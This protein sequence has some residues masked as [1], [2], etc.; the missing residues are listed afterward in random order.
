MRSEVEL[1][2][3]ARLAD[4]GM[5]CAAWLRAPHR[6]GAVVPSGLPLAAAMAR[7]VPRGSG[8][9]VELGGGTGS[10]TA[11]LLHAGVPVRELII[12]ERDP[13][14]AQRLQSRFSGCRVLCGDARRLSQLLS[15]HGIG[16]PVKAVVSSLPLLIMPPGVC[17]E[18]IGGVGEL[19]ADRGP[20]VQYTYGFGCPL[21]A[22]T[23]TRGKV[24]ASRVTRVWRNLPPASVWRFDSGLH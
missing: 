15:S 23:L 19:V 17:T 3:R 8:L 16:E 10:I 2:V 20:M 24:R 18:L 7:E 4:A 5:L 9:V 22:R 13:R 1:G 6:I 11:G 12:L 14:L 21:P